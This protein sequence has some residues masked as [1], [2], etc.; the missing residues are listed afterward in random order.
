V[1]ANANILGSMSLDVSELRDFYQTPLGQVVR[2]LLAARIRSRWAVARGQSV[3]GLGFATPYLGS[4][5]TEAAHVAALMPSTQGALVW[6]R[7][8]GVLTALVEEDQLPLGDASVDKLLAVHALEGAERVRPLL[9]EMWRVLAPEGRLIIVVP[10]RRGVWARL[11]STP[12]GYGRPYSRTQLTR[13]LEESML[14]PV[15][16]SPALF[17]PPVDK[18]LV[19]KSAVAWERVGARFTPGFGGVLVVEAKKELV[20]AIGKTARARGV[21]ELAISIRR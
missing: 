17:M 10:N 11:D 19:V 16:W 8:G 1:A 9:R 7:S 2:R 4:F 13:L 18:R 6:P 12:F 21:R 20:A 15:E 14:T 5:R 3:V